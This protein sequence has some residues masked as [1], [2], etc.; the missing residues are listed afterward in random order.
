MTLLQSLIN[1]GTLTMFED[2][3]VWWPESGDMYTVGSIGI[4]LTKDQVAALE[5]T[6]KVAGA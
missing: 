6:E 2:H 5:E 4:I 3:Y 1:D